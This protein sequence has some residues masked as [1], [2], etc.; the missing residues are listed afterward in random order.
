MSLASSA[1]PDLPAAPAA[2]SSVR[3]LASDASTRVELL[4]TDDARLVRKSSWFRGLVGLRTLWRQSRAE[5]EF[6]CLRDLE[7]HGVPCVHAVSWRD[8]RSGG[9]VQQCELV[10]ECAE[11]AVDL[12]ALLRA[13]T[14][15]AARRELAVDLGALLRVL[16]AAG[17]RSTTASPR[18]VLRRGDGALVYCDQPYAARLRWP[19]AAWGRGLDLF[20]TFFSSARRR[21]WSATERLRGL[22]AYVGGDRALA[23]QLW[24]RMS[25]RP[26]V[27]Y[28][29]ARQFCRLAAF[30]KP[31]TATALR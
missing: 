13:G 27:W 31:S 12:R 29:L 22:L 28:R 23:R 24:R 4:E 21:E 26:R 16:H 10:T 30:R 7:Q 8:W 20:D 6:R 11:D 15:P 9:R 2:A 5:R 17:F 1:T 19:F 18:N 3:L 14:Q 25:R